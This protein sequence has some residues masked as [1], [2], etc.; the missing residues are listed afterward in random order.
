MAEANAFTSGDR[1]V[2][3]LTPTPEVGAYGPSRAARMPFGKHRQTSDPY[4][5]SQEGQV[6]PTEHHQAHQGSTMGGEI[7]FTVND[8]GESCL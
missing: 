3:E 4:Q 6:F 5:S 1:G 7:I 8:D 2:T